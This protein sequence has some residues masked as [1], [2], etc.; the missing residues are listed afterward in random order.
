MAP[1]P[2]I[3]RCLRPLFA[4]CAL[5]ALLI[6]GGCGGGSGA[7][8]NPFAPGTPTPGPLFVLPAAATIYSNTPAT[9]TITGGAPPYFVVSSNT[10]VLPV[11]STS[12]GTIVLLPANVAS[13]TLVSITV[14]DSIGQ[15]AIASVT[16][17]AAPIFNTLTIKP[18]ASTCGAATICSGQT[19]TV[20]VTVTGP[21]GVG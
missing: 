8:N 11:A 21:G 12:T 2:M 19:G 6:L 14:R 7:P 4:F 15:N 16:V 13:D 10:A 1:T 17:K 20:S 9:L 5:G 18:S 3:T